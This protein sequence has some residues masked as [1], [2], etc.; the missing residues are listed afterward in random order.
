MAEK[1]EGRFVPL[2][3]A[4]MSMMANLEDIRDSPNIDVSPEWLKNILENSSDDLTANTVT[5]AMTHELFAVIDLSIA[6]SERKREKLIEEQM[7]QQMAQQAALKEEIAEANIVERVLSD[8]K[9]ELQTC[10]KEVQKQKE[11][12]S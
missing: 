12:L 9:D 1:T 5:P 2:K 4:M 8:L 6:R 11:C 3:K 10:S 7:A